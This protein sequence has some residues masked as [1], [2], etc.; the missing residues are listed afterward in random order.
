MRGI[1]IAICLVI[2]QLSIKTQAQ[3]AGYAPPDN[4]LIPVESKTFDGVM[5]QR[6]AMALTLLFDSGAEYKYLNVPASVFY[7]FLNARNKG[8]FF[9]R[10]IR[11]IYPYERIY[12]W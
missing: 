7:E 12:S 6:R 11:P 8:Q 3:C 1:I 9:H 2:F 4:V 10:H 5:Y